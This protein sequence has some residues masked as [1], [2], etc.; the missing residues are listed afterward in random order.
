MRAAAALLVVLAAGTLPGNA[1]L[2]SMHSLARQDPAAPPRIG[3]FRLSRPG[4]GD[5]FDP[6]P[7]GIRGFCATKGLQPLQRP[8]RIIEVTT[9]LR[10]TH[11]LATKLRE[12]HDIVDTFV[13]VEG[14]TTF[15]GEPVRPWLREGLLSELG[16]WLGNKVIALTQD[17]LPPC[18]DIAPRLVNVTDVKLP[19]ASE[20]LGA[21]KCNW[22]YETERRRVGL[23][24]VLERLGVQTATWWWWVDAD[25]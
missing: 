13:V 18:A 3:H 4:D 12:L 21:W 2:A 9:F 20:P 14:T 8:A 6:S 24:Y 17:G 15:S 5:D 7:E 25:R 16:P 11:L 10:E 19:D 22:A 1:K 23:S